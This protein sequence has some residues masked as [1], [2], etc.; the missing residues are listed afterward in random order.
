MNENNQNQHENPKNSDSV[1]LQEVSSYLRQNTF[2]KSSRTEDQKR[3]E[4]LIEKDFWKRLGASIHQENIVAT[5]QVYIKWMRS[6]LEDS[7]IT[8]TLIDNNSTWHEIASQ[9]QLEKCDSFAKVL[10]TANWVCSHFDEYHPVT[11]SH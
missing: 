7:Q 9:A 5:V 1:S 10:Y 4:M 11:V 3:I 8:S 2:R 6:T